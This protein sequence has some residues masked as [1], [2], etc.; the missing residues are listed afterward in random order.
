MN[1]YFK[2]KIK[3]NTF[4]LK[5]RVNISLFDFFDEWQIEVYWTFIL[6]RIGS[7]KSKVSKRKIFYVNVPL[8]FAGGKKKFA[9]NKFEIDF[10]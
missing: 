7:W 4:Y 5:W 6:G 1:T 10:G 9:W 3:F 2:R 8:I